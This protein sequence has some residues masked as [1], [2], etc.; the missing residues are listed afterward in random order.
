[1]LSILGG[2]GRW[3]L[4]L[5]LGGLYGKVITQA[6]DEGQHKLD[7]AVIHAQTTNDAA[8]TEVQIVKDQAAV[9]E[10]QDSLPPDPKDPFNNTDWNSGT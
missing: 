4:K 8:K 9:K 5:F 10:K 2:L 3:L 7:A 1:M 6:E